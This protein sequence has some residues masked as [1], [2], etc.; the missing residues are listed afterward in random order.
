MGTPSFGV[1]ELQPDGDVISFSPPIALVSNFATYRDTVNDR[2]VAKMEI[3][4]NR[5]AR[6]Y[7][8]T[9]RQTKERP[10]AERSVLKAKFATES[11]EIPNNTTV[12]AEI[13]DTEKMRIPFFQF[14]DMAKFKQ[15]DNQGRPIR[16][17]LQ[18]TV[19]LNLLQS[20]T[21]GTPTR[22]AVTMQFDIQ[23]DHPSVSLIDKTRA[24]FANF[25]VGPADPSHSHSVT[26]LGQLQEPVNI[27]VR[28]GFKTRVVTLPIGF[29]MMIPIFRGKIRFEDK[30]PTRW[31]PEPPTYETVAAPIFMPVV[32]TSPV[33]PPPG[34]PPPAGPPPN[35][36]VVP[37]TPVPGPDL[38]NAP[39]LPAQ[40]A[41]PVLGPAPG[42][43]PPPDL[44]D[45]MGEADVLQPPVPAEPAA[46][47]EA[48]AP[49]EPAAA[50][51]EAAAPAEPAAAIAEAAAP[52][53][54]AAAIAEAAAPA[55]ELAEA[56]PPIDELN[57][58]PEETVREGVITDSFEN[59]IVDAI[60]EFIDRVEP[61][62]ESSKTLLRGYAPLAEMLQRFK[63]AH[64]NDRYS[65]K[66]PKR[67][68]PTRYTSTP[69][70]NGEY[71]TIHLEF[72]D[73]QPFSF[74]FILSHAA[75]VA[76]PPP[77][78]PAGPRSRV[79]VASN[80]P[81]RMQPNREVLNYLQLD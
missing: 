27:S 15:M 76:A 11:V 34:P 20:G 77:A 53:E 9:L 78:P 50:I 33:Q 62:D 23:S 8:D 39:P 55:A 66:L 36:P 73:D 59:E 44:A 37:A 47:A 56:P 48:A 70:A 65:L 51:A 30:R 40:P 25:V 38:G 81:F 7:I 29:T 43:A 45:L 2:L 54:P 80:A 74:D 64:M 61:K 21:D 72:N 60:S 17:I 58:A 16:E 10:G 19:K 6:P 41:A 63:T 18:K 52:A 5:N 12:T 26:L 13:G 1:I 31:T 75:Q 28:E 24:S 32:P 67:E 42:P 57:P 69:P 3:V 22:G 49:A 68:A 35:M 79:I 46:I 71:E 4:P 14:A